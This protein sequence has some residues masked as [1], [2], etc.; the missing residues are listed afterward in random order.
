VINKVQRRFKARQGWARL[1]R[2][3][4]GALARLPYRNLVFI[5]RRRNA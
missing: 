5:V 3:A 4:A 1:V 2:A